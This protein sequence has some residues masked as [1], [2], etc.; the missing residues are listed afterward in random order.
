MPTAGAAPGGG[1]KLSL[2]LANPISSTEIATVLPLL[3]GIKWPGRDFPVLEACVRPIACLDRHR[4]SWGGSWS[5]NYFEDSF[6]FSP[7]TL[8]SQAE[9]KRKQGSKFEVEEMPALCLIGP[10]RTIVGVEINPNV[11][12]DRFARVFD[13][14]LF[15]KRIV[16][17][18]KRDSRVA[19][20]DVQERIACKPFA[21]ADFRSWHS[22]RPKNQ[23]DSLVWEPSKRRADCE[24]L[25]KQV[26]RIL[27]VAADT[28]RLWT[29]FREAFPDWNQ[30][31]SD[32]VLSP[33]ERGAGRSVVVG[34]VDDLPIEVPVDESTMEFLTGVA[35]SFGWDWPLGPDNN[36]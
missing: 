3:N 25:A 11:A 23:G 26:A 5:S 16:E 4:N 33:V 30:A 15:A 35:R 14:P 12:R 31:P 34:W 24:A 17:A 6:S 32:M 21:E 1:I 19:W 9:K 18:Y 28:R 29:I 20:L 8:Q 7:G 27:S 36:C 22:R 10:R 2:T 13:G